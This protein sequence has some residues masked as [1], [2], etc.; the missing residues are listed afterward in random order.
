MRAISGSC[1]AHRPLAFRVG[2]A[3][4][5]ARQA[6]AVEAKTAQLQ[7]ATEAAAANLAPEVPPR[8]PLCAQALLFGLSVLQQRQAAEHYMSAVNADTA[9]AI[10]AARS[11]QIPQARKE[12]RVL[13]SEVRPPLTRTNRRESRVCGHE[14]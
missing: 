3:T 8:L 13:C 12:S 2:N 14:R 9:G 4:E 6:D 5:T 10:A 1:T 11:N 7:R